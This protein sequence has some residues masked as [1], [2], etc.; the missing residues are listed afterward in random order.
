M[1]T[2]LDA[3]RMAG[4]A[5]ADRAREILA[6]AQELH[7]EGV[8]TPGRLKQIMDSLEHGYIFEAKDRLERG[9]AVHLLQSDDTCFAVPSPDTP[10][11]VLRRVMDGY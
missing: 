2:M 5:R 7:D 11:H 9:I 4:K 1:E 6:A 3:V 10:V 8:I